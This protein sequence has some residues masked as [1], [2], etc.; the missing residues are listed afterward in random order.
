MLG[1]EVDPDFSPGFE[2]V[3]TMVPILVASVFLPLFLRRT[4][5]ATRKWSRQYHLHRPFTTDIDQTSLRVSE[6]FVTV[7]YQWAYFRGYTQSPNLFLL[8]PTALL[9]IMIPKRAF[10]TP[11]ARQQFADFLART[12]VPP[13][14]AFPVLPALPL[15]ALP[16]ATPPSPPSVTTHTESPLVRD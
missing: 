8:Y 9:V 2:T 16:V 7:T 4:N 13:A 6:P 1:D 3:I 12:I 15:P 14:N 10:P 11:D 5:T